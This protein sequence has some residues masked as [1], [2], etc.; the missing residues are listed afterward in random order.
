LFKEEVEAK[1]G[2]TIDDSDSSEENEIDSD[3]EI[4]NEIKN[5]PV[6]RLKK[7]TRAQKNLKLL[8]RMRR[9]V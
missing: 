2:K 5:K 6:D 4:G 8:K 1:K 7:L 3:D 9:E